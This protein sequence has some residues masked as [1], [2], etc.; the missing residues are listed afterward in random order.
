MAV[1]VR[2]RPVGSGKWWIFTD[3]K[4]KRLARYIPQGK[5][6]AEEIA[7][8]ITE[9]LEL[10]QANRR[11]GISFSLREVVLG[12]PDVPAPATPIPT[13]P[14]F[15]SYADSWL[16]GC[17]VRGLKHTTYR[18]YKV[19]LDTHLKPAF[20]TKHLSEIDRK[21]VRQFAHA[22]KESLILNRMQRHR[23]PMPHRSS[24]GNDL[25]ALYN[26]YFA[27]S[28]VCSTKRSRT[29]WS[30]ITQH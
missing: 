16:E 4:G 2:E 12:R 6:A 8:R 11:H 27:A 30:S 5:H 28:L 18:A 25:L 24:H 26:I 15:P 7:R 20:G 1:K 9:K 22:A 13:T 19:I 3:W 14:L 21:T 10:I 17:K 23:N 29:D